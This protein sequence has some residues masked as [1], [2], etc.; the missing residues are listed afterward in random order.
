M[1]KSIVDKKIPVGQIKKFEVTGTDR[2]GKRFK[3]TTNSYTHANMI[4]VYNGS[5]WA[6]MESGNR[7]LLRRVHN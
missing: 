3:I 4:N 5:V 7:I 6:R 2:D 1:S